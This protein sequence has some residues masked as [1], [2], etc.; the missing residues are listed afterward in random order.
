MHWI[1]WEKLLAEPK[2]Q[3]FVDVLERLDMSYSLHKIVPF[4][5]ELMPEPI[6]ED[7][8]AIC[9]GPYSMRHYAAKHQLTPGVYDLEPYN[10]EVQKS[11]WG[12][13]MLNFDSEVVAFEDANPTMEEFFTRPIEDSKSFAG[14]VMTRA[15]FLEWRDKV[16]LQNLDFGVGTISS[17]DKI[18]ISSLKTIHAEYRCFAVGGQIVTA[19]IYK[20]GTKI[21]YEEIDK[22][23]TAWQY[24]QEMVNL[25]QPQEAFAID[26]AETPEG[27]RI[28][29]INTINSCGL[30]A[31]NCYKLITAISSIADILPKTVDFS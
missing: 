19:S 4:V 30:Y 21:F 18:Q 10:F 12:R 11:V 23:H 26:V 13:E 7:K 14:A 24:A 6:V 27:H 28:I 2:G 31:A 20:R 8:R 9:F 25:W 5:G 16:C 29:E 3:E 17:S 1:L 15:D 22:N